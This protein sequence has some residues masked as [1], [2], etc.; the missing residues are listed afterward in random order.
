MIIVSRSLRQIARNDMSIECLVCIPRTEV[1]LSN[2]RALHDGNNV[3]L[4][5]GTLL[6]GRIQNRDAIVR[7]NY[8]IRSISLSRVQDPR[9]K[10]DELAWLSM[11]A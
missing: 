9:E 5:P 10:I 6:I 3:V 11:N 4:Y 2:K 8:R 7:H 1:E